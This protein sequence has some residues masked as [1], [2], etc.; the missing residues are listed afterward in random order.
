MYTDQ[1]IASGY[2]EEVVGSSKVNTTSALENCETSSIGRALANAG[3]SPKGSRPSAQEMNKIERV[4]V[5]HSDQTIQDDP[6]ATANAIATAGESL[7]A[8]VTSMDTLRGPAAGNARAQ[9]GATE[10]QRAFIT[11]L[12]MAEHPDVADVETS[13]AAVNVLLQRGE[14]GSVTTIEELSKIQ[15][16]YLIEALKGGSL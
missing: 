10:K 2:A 11:R 12:L 9:G 13:I 6:W 16:S 3:F 5:S 15:A 14:R 8:V 7:G 4:K 1:L